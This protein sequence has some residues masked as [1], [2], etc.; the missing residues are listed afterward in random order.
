MVFDSFGEMTVAPG[1]DPSKKGEGKWRYASVKFGKVSLEKPTFLGG[2]GK[3]YNMLPRH[4]RLQKMA[5]SSRM[6]VNVH[7]Q[8]YTLQLVKSDKFKTGTKQYLDRNIINED[9]RDIFIGRIPVM[10]NSDLCWMK[11]VGKGY[12]DFDHGG[13]F[14]IK[15][16]EKD[17]LPSR[18][19]PGQL[20]DAALGKGFACGG[21]MRHATPFSTLS[22]DAIMDH[23]HR[24][25]RL[26]L[27][28][29]KSWIFKRGK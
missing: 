22:V 1:Y 11:E 19:P 15:G 17:T 2:E 6:K 24:Y 7:V 12:C 16:A 26:D 21:L 23:L 18:Q 5:Y 4:A 3:A 28:S 29:I 10:V 27:I 14:W 25:Y 20:L 13:Y 9:D 8:V